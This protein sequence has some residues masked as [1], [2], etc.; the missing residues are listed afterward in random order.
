MNKIVFTRNE[1]GKGVMKTNMSRGTLVA[2]QERMDAY[3]EVDKVF[4]KIDEIHEKIKNLG[5]TKDL[6]L[7]PLLD[8]LDELESELSS[9]SIQYGEKILKAKMA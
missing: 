4:E 3:G 8:Q 1:N 9:A 2:I 6:D 7:S 5:K